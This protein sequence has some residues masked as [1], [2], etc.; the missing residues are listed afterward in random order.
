MRKNIQVKI[1]TI[2]IHDISK[3]FALLFLKH[4]VYAGF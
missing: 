2:I 4:W 1:R 3:L